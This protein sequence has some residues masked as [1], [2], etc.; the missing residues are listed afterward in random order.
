MKRVVDPHQLRP[1]NTALRCWHVFFCSA[2]EADPI[3]DA[4]LLHCISHCSVAAGQIK[5]NNEALQA[6]ERA[7]EPPRDQGF[8]RPKVSGFRSGVGQGFVQMS[9]ILDIL[10]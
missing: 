4:Y 8:T 6:G 5:K 9:F 7:E 3:A 10:L 1:F 2:E